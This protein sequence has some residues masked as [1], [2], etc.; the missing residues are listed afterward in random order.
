MLE[1]K[2]LIFYV[3]P[4]KALH[5]RVRSRTIRPDLVAGWSS[6]VARRAHNPKVVGSNPA[7]ATNLFLTIIKKAQMGLFSCLFFGVNGLAQ[8]DSLTELLEPAVKA[9]GLELWGMEYLP[10]GRHSLLRVFIEKE[11]GVN[12]EDCEKAS[13]QISAVLEV[14]D[15]IPQEYV[16]EVSSPGLDRFL[17]KPSQ[18]LTFCGEIVSLRLHSPIESQ[19]KMRGVLS[20]VHEESVVIV[21]DGKP[22]TVAF[23]NIQKAQIVPVFK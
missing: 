15:P 5:C 17:F 20:E 19:K 12:V 13:R 4:P 10:A 7:P 23:S 21:V 14:E 3:L 6:L 8:E 9:L 2:N 11:E 18:Y 16:L 22:V 1:L